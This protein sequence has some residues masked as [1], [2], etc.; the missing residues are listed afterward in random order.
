MP[1]LDISFYY[2]QFFWLAIVFGSLYLL[3]H[4][5]LLP[6]IEG[7]MNKRDAKIK[8]D[9]QTAEALTKEVETIKEQVVAE[10]S[11]ARR[12]ANERI[13]EA[14]KNAQKEMENQLA[15]LDK[16]LREKEKM[17]EENIIEFK[18]SAN[19]TILPIATSMVIEILSKFLGESIDQN[20][21]NNELKKV[22]SSN[23]NTK[24]II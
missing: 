24:N 12:L 6:G 23:D 22:Q 1:Q 9:L 18:R 17:T 5:I 11:V 3:S 20:T 7:I 13:S 15:K 14:S 19:E 4:F 10:I 2:S 16:S 8:N 21:I